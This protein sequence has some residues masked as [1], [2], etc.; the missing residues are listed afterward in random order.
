[1]RVE[2]GEQFLDTAF[3][4]KLLNNE[5]AM[6]EIRTTFPLAREGKVIGPNRYHFVLRYV[7]A[8]VT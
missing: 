1:M 4:G 6:E 7:V 2:V 3:I 8:V 5:E